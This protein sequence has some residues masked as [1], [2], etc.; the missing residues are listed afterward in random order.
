VTSRP[1]KPNDQIY[2]FGIGFGDVTPAILPGVIAGGGTDLVN[3]VTISFGATPATIGYQGL[4][5]SAVGLYQFNFT[6]PPGL[7]NGDYQIN[8]KQ[9]GIV[10]PQTLYLT[11]HN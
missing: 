8:V 10:V 5:P 6:V 11:V 1:A 4:T 2:T 9:N 3:H 7:A